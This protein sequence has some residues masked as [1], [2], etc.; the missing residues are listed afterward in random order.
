MGYCYD[1]TMIV[2]IQSPLQKST[3]ITGINFSE[4]L[5]LG[6]GNSFFAKSTKNRKS[7]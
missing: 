6:H 2:A 4:I 3:K 1:N 7:S 5:L